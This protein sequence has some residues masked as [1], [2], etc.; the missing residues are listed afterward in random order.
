MKSLAVLAAVAIC[1]A[2]GLFGWAGRSYRAETRQ[3]LPAEIE[4]PERD[5]GERPVGKSSVVFRI[6]NPTDHP[7]EVVGAPDGCGILCC[8][9]ATVTD[10]QTIPPGGALDLTCELMVAAAEPFEYKCKIYLSDN[11]LRPIKVSVRGVGVK[12]ASGA[13][14]APKS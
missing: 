13:A 4:E 1:A 8:L 12:A 5:L 3:V 6:T 11:G 14:H 9:K 7:V 10:R 2:L